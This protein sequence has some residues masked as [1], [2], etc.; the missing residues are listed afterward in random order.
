MNKHTKSSRAL[1]AVAAIWIAVA[2]Y[3]GCADEKSPEAKENDPTKAV[4]T[5]KSGE[6]RIL[7]GNGEEITV[8]KPVKRI[9]IEY[10]DNAELIRILQNSDNVVGVSGLNYIFE[11]CELQF[12]EFRKK[13][14]VGYFSGLDYEAILNLKADLLLTFGPHTREKIIN[15]PGVAVVYL[16]LYYPD[17]LNPSE[18]TFVRGVKNLGMILDKEKRAEEYIG[19]YLG[20]IDKIKSRTKDLSEDDKPKVF[21]AQAN[22]PVLDSTTY[23]TYPVKDAL[24]QACLVAGGR[25]IAA[26]LPEFAGKATGIQVD[27]EWLIAQNPDIMILHAVDRVD[28]YGYEADGITGVREELGKFLKRP[29]LANVK[30]VKD[31]KVF[32][33]DGHF[34]NDASGGALGAAYMAKMFHP[35]IFADMDPEAFHNEFLEMQGLDYNVNHHGIFVYPP[36][37]TAD[38]LIG[39]PDKYAGEIF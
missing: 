18:S 11:E 38:G 7:D 17:L 23:S 39:I 22:A 28:L 21:I 32:L 20:L 10:T 3:P 15:L 8:R 1:L 27:P 26:E 6:I 9:I 31:R 24:T 30:A 16:G 29:E 25:T 13:P 36:L 14:S 37:R 33:F 34:R 35:E 5:E 12:P 19:W 4:S 2:I